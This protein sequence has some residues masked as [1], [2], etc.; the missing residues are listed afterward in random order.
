M[1]KVIWFLCL[2]LVLGFSV[3]E[4]G[5]GDISSNGTDDT[6]E[7]PTEEVVGAEGETCDQLSGE[8]CGSGYICSETAIFTKGSEYC[9]LSPCVSLESDS[10]KFY[11]LEF[12][13]AIWL[14]LLVL[15]IVGLFIWSLFNSPK[16]SWDKNKIKVDKVVQ[17]VPKVNKSQ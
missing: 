5:W 16:N 3:A 17:V 1:E 4:D 10:A 11:K 12:F 14:I 9:C 7:T 6:S 15:G 13:G 8:I 2:V